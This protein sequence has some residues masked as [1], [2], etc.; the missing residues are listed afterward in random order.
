MRLLT[1]DQKY[2]MNEES[3][4]EDGEISISEVADEDDQS[5]A[6]IFRKSPDALRK[7][8][9]EQV[10][11]WLDQ[12]G[13]PVHTSGAEKLLETA[14][15][16]DLFQF[17][18]YRSFIQGSVA[19]QNLLC[20]MRQHSQLSTGDP[21]C[22]INISESIGRHIRMQQ[23][24]RTVSRRRPTPL[25]NMTIELDWNPHEF[26]QSAGLDSIPADILDRTI[27]ITGTWHEAQ[28][29]TVTVYLQQTWP[30]TGDHIL[31]LLRKLLSGSGQQCE[32]EF[33]CN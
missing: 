19:Y 31:S 22:M 14:I 32:G 28:A 20:R 2:A 33:L 27:C 13:N 10:P 12:Y 8:L 30:V 25:V 16:E 17:P 24:G 6:R 3:I 26:F 5:S 21:N 15:E 18:D 1:N 9:D 23:A 29:T 7:W 11:L 4:D